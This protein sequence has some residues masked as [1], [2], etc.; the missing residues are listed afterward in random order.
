MDLETKNKNASEYKRNMI[1][2]SVLALIVIP[3]GFYID[4][5]IGMG[6]IV[7]SAISISSTFIMSKKFARNDEIEYA[8]TATVNSQDIKENLAVETLVLND[9]E[10]SIPVEELDDKVIHYEKKSI[11]RKLSS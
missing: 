11:S 6:A 8:K 3:F 10:H 4:P 9:E 5:M 2:V 1:A 7:L